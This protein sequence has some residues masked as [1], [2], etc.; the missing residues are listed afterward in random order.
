VLHSVSDDFTIVQPQ[1][2]ARHCL[3]LAACGKFPKILTNLV[4][5]IYWLVSFDRR[6]A[7]L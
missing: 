2:Q 6:G 1:F 5:R 7:L 4:V 3:F